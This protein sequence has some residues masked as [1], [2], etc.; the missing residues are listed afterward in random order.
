MPIEVFTGR[1]GAGKTAILCEKLLFVLRRNENYYKKSGKIRKVWLNFP[2]NELYVKKYSKFLGWWEDVDQLVKLEDCDIFIDEL[3]YYFD[4]Q[5]WKE[6]TRKVKKFIAI[7]RH[8]GIEI[9][10]TSQDFAQ[11]DISFRRLTDTLFYL[12]KLGSSR[13]PSA[14]KPPV[15]FIWGVSVV[16]TIPPT[17]YK[18]DQKENKTSFHWVFFLTRKKT[19]IY[20]TRQKYKMA[21]FAP[22][23]HIVRVCSDPNCKE[24]H[25]GSVFRKVIHT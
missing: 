10:A 9:Y 12:V 2:I 3:L 5:L 4:A 25:Q 11:V 18:E 20:D 17:D 21:E 24:G 15:R 22:Y 7:H 23:E 6:T 13:E 19:E 1:A 8:L 16:Y 14:T